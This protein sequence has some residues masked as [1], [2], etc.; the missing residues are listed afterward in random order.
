M[1]QATDKNRAKMIRYFGDI[2]DYS[3]TKFLEDNGWK[4]RP[5]W[6]WERPTP[7]HV[8][9]PKESDCLWFLIDEWDYGGIK[10]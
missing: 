2:G 1:P 9:T 7:E 5:D 8:T 3:P 4:L 6:L 10:E